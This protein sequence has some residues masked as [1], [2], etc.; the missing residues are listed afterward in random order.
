MIFVSANVKKLLGYSPG[1]F[2]I[3]FHDIL[4]DYGSWKELLQQLRSRNKT[5]APLALHRLAETNSGTLCAWDVY[6]GHV[7][8]GQDHYAVVLFYPA[9]CLIKRP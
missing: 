6:L 9:F 2:R 4:H 1:D 8:R 5:Y 7:Q 3:R